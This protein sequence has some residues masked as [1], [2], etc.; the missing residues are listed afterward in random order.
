MY[1]ESMGRKNVFGKCGEEVCIWK[2]WRGSM[3]LE[4]MGRSRKYVFGKYGEEVCIWK[5]SQYFIDISSSEPFESN[6]LS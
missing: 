5:V 2:V 4:S 3:Y 6:I 1:L